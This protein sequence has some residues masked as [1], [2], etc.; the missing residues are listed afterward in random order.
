MKT[1][2][3]LLF[4]TALM[5]ICLESKG[6]NNASRVQQFDSLRVKAQRLLN[7]SEE[8]VYLDS[9]LNLAQEMDSVRLQ[10]QA[11][12]HM[13]RNY[14]NRMKPD[15]LMYWSDMLDDMALE[16]KH[17]SMFFDTYSLVCFW[18]MYDKNY[19]SALDKANRLYQL[20][21]DL[22]NADG[23]IAS[24]ETIGLIYMETFR[25][26]EAIKSYTEGLELQRQQKNPRYGYQ[27]QFMSY[28]I[29][30]YLKLRDYRGVK[31]ALDVAYR[32]VEQCKSSESFFP[33]ERCLWLLAC[34]NIEM[35]V[36]QKM[37]QKAESYIIEAENYKGV[38]DFYVFCYFHLVSASYYQLLGNYNQALENVNMVLSQ[39]GDDYLP[40][41]KIKA[42]LLLNA[43]KGQE[44]ALLYHKSV[45]LIDS[46]YNESLSKQINQL[47]TIHEV[48][49]LELRNKQ[50]ELETGR[51]K[52]TVTLILSFV[53][54]LALSVIVVHYIRV[55][56]MKNLLEIS[57]RELKKDKEQLLIS[58]KALMAAKENAETSN[59]LKDKFL[60][61]LSHEIRTPLNSIIGFSS[62]LSA[63]ADN[64]ES[65]EYV[66]VI[67]HN[68]DL[69]LKLVNDTVSV[70]LL[71]TDQIPFMLEE[72]E[73]NHYCR[74]ILQGFES[75]VSSMVSLNFCSS[76]DC[77]QV[78]RT[79]VKLF[80]QILTNLLSNAIKFTEKGQI[81]LIYSI[82]G[83]KENVHFIVEDTGCGISKDMQGRIFDSFEKG[84]IHTQGIGLG[85]TIC[86]LAASRLGGTVTLDTS[87]KKGTRMIF[88][89]PI[90]Y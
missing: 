67:K 76:D 16:H 59:R 44:S 72:I 79:D 38:E 83:K 84:D 9:M 64:P 61:S 71:Q 49:K 37:P 88:T 28:I 47:R 60:S 58:E 39:T 23:M 53:L 42:E 56:R 2:F 1:K 13:A 36:A 73:I 52:L 19:D 22:D 54:F 32:L 4:F 45:N 31:E 17:Y 29:E 21:K 46:T 10:C 51:Y 12:A 66:S 50:V 80:K 89:H 90:I 33:V 26:V 86:K 75:S 63:M 35:Y 14:Y 85:L 62:L 74:T 82:D 25:Y 87:Y 41:L 70:S 30:S 69:L 55:K 18:E 65:K 57:D 8:I 6:M 11:M 15:S 43:G 81:R 3:I 5:L 20:A 48:D 77:L 40:A 78:L 27:F 7:T 68:S 24:Y 34:Y